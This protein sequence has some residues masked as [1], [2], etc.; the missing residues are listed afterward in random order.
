MNIIK[1]NYI[2]IKVIKMSS[3]NNSKVEYQE[4]ASSMFQNQNSNKYN[5]KNMM[6]FNKL[7]NISDYLQFVT[8][9]LF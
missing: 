2:L 6:A 4:F 3:R 8:T 5:E 7:N 9:Y 1:I